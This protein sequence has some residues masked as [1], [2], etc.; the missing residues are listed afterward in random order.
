LK[1]AVRT[2]VLETSRDASMTLRRV[3]SLEVTYIVKTAKGDLL[4]H[5]HSILASWRNHF[6]QLLNVHGVNDVRQTEIPT[7]EPLVP[8]HSDSEVEM[9]VERLKIYKSAGID[10]IPAELIQADCREVY[11]EIT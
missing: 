7:A 6:F 10:Q 4:A 2:R 1:Q 11:S 9:A 5:S 3:T 8:E